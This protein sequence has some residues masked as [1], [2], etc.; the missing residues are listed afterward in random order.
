MHK[1]YIIPLLLICSNIFMTFA[2]YG[3]LK[4]NFSNKHHLLFVILISWSIAFFEYCFMVPANRLGHSLGIPTAQLKIMQEVITF[5]VFIPFMLF[6]LKEKWQWDYLWAI[7]CLIG[8]VYFAFR[9]TNS[10]PQPQQSI[11]K[12]HLTSASSDAIH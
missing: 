11:E 10:A 9:N 4:N 12:T 8:A 5:S 1:F 7:F 6:Y 3:H 2:W